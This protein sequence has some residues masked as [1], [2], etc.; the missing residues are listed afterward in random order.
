[1]INTTFIILPNKK[2]INL[3]LHYYYNFLVKDKKMGFKVK[4]MHY[5]QIVKF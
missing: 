4:L 1:M 5:L 3:N 2:K